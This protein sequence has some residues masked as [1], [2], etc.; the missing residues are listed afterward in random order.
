MQ[1][2]W[3]EKT[4]FK[5]IKQTILSCSDYNVDDKHT[6]VKKKTVTQA[7]ESIFMYSR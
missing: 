1:F 2:W 3:A 4:S 5:N 7:W 6:N